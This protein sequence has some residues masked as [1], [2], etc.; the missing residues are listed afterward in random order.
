[1]WQDQPIPSEVYERWKS[2][3]YF[4]ANC[5]IIMGKVWRGQYF[6]KY[7]A[8]IDI[9]NSKGIK[10]FLSKSEKVDS[11]DK[12]AE[13][14][15]VEQHLDAKDKKVHIYFIVETP[16][17]KRSGIGGPNNKNED[18]PAIEVKSEGK[19][20]LMCC[21]PSVHTNGHPSQIIG[22]RIPLV[23]I[24]NNSKILE[25]QID[26]IYKVY[27]QNINHSNS[28]L[29]T[30]LRLIATTRR[31]GSNPP[32]ISKGSRSNTLISLVRVY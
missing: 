14:T 8:C 1:M 23:L 10:E 15:I 21:T 5:A 6:G 16:L 11:L 30:E 3:G 2:S 4:N 24:E 12:L 26:R 32:K 20:G 18:I 25:D 13:K 9:D 22:T 27:S 28:N 19:H 7:L 17:T 29:T 31:I